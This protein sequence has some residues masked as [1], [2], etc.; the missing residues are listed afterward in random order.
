MNLVVLSG[1]AILFTTASRRRRAR[2]SIAAAAGQDAGH[3]PGR[4]AFA[5]L[6]ADKPLRSGSARR[7]V[8]SFAISTSFRRA[9][10]YMAVYRHVGG[11]QAPIIVRFDIGGR[12]GRRLHR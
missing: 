4:T 12:A 10:M 9:D 3:Q 8:A 11:C 5:D 2:N 1:A 7:P 6:P